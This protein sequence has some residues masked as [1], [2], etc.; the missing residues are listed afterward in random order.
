MKKYFCYEK[1]T[2]NYITTCYGITDVLNL[3]LFVREKGSD[4]YIREV[5][6]SK[7]T[8]KKVFS[9]KAVATITKN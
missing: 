9:K 1:T 2:N 5:P 3:Q 8:I 4:L 6:I 7:K